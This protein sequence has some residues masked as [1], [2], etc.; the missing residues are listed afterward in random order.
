MFIF[1]RELDRVKPTHVLNAA[2]LV[3]S[4]LMSVGENIPY[5]FYFLH[6]LTISCVQTGRP[7]VDWC[8]DHK[9]DTIRYAFDTFQTERRTRA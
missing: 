2:G 3:K 6:L 1:L 9:E 5:F 8:E 7:T 4:C